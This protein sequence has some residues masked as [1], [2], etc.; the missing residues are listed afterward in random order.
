VASGNTS[1]ARPAGHV[2]PW[3]EAVAVLTGTFMV[4][5]DTTVV[6]VSLPQIAGSL[7]A[8]VE[9]STWA[10]T[11][12]LAANAV[13]LPMTGWLATYFGRKR[14]LLLSI[15]GFT[16]ASFLCGLAPTLSFLII[17]RIIQG[18][19]GGVMQPL[20]QSI[21]LEAFPP[22]ERGKAMGF[23]GIGI[24]VAPVLG[25][26][27]GGWL[28]DNYSWRWVFYINVP[29]GIAAVVLNSRYIFDPAYLKRQISRVDYWG[30]S[31]LAI[32]I[33]ALQITLDKGEQED[34]FS[35]HLI[36]VLAI[37][38]IAGLVA[39]V[40]RELRV[41]DPIIDLHVFRERTYATGAF[42][43][44]LV[45]FVLF[46]SLVLVPIML[47]VLLRYPPLQ[48]GIAMAPRGLGS[49]IAM[50]LVGILMARID[51]RKLLALGFLLGAWTM[52]WL[53]G[54]D[55]SV[56]YWDIFWPQFI[57][58][59]ALGLMFVPLTTITMDRIP[60]EHMGNATSLFNLVRNIGGSAGIAIV[61]TRLANSRQ[62]HT[63][64]LAGHID[65]Y[66]LQN[67]LWLANLRAA[68]LARGADAATATQRAYAAA[69][70]MVQQQA[71]ILSFIDAFVFLGAVFLLMTP[72]ILLMRR[73]THAAEH[74]AAP[75][76]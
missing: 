20:S 10:L 52:F 61:E 17:C 19:T 11:S 26:V 71:A 42:L 31:Y 27:L 75:A 43:I 12:Y 64:V 15:I 8:T 53:A 39:L 37:V 47:Q 65:A 69:W 3:L 45:G 5:L 67:Q 33:A 30:L 6:N 44:T 57:Q 9:E 16:S 28:T 40:I 23:W 7:S 29:I 74:P 49:L 70:G 58:G 59:V 14:L 60:R 51:P 25:P 63:N 50:P 2:H 62:F 13:I 41:R 24:V 76:E 36:V 18:A 56:G 21:M 54:F 68:F 35:S 22:A 55:L 38:A 4:V 72:L 32:G 48:A 66:G 46:A 1:G 34:W 73:P